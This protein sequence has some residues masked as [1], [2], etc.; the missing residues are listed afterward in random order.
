[1]DLLLYDDDRSN[2]PYKMAHH[3]LH[4]VDLGHLSG[5]TGET[6]RRGLNPVEI[7]RIILGDVNQVASQDVHIVTYV[8]H[9]LAV[10]SIGRLPSQPTLPE[11]SAYST[12]DSMTLI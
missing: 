8:L 6:C 2:G 11:R 1:M 7:L 4:P 12:Q 9:S 10:K 5:A 3:W